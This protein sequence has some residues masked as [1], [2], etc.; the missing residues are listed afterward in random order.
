MAAPRLAA[1]VLLLLVAIAAAIVANV[2]NGRMTLAI[3]AIEG[4]RRSFWRPAFLIWRDYARLCPG[5]P[6][7]SGVWIANAVF[8]AAAIGFTLCL[9]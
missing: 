9:R 6:L 4:R 5:A 8:A 2:Q 1:A 3:R 7:L